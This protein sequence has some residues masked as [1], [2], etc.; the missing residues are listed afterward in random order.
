VLPSQEYRQIL[1]SGCNFGMNLEALAWL[2]LII[3][4][5]AMLMPRYSSQNYTLVS[6]TGVHSEPRLS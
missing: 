4:L 1:D 3:M 2:L 5:Q 6:L